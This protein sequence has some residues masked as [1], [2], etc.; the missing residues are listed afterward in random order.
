[1]GKHKVLFKSSFSLTKVLNMAN[2]R[3]IEVMLVQTPNQPVQNSV[4][5]CNVII[6]KLFNLLLLN[7]IQLLSIGMTSARL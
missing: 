6:C 5:L 7:L 4:T 1:M 2:V 3:R